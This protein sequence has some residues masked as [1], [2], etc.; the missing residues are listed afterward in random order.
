MTPVSGATFITYPTVTVVVAGGVVTTV[1]LVTAGI[2]ASSTAATV[3]TVAAALIG[4]T[5]SGFSIAVST[6]VTGASN[7][8]IGYQT[9]VANTAGSS[10][11][12][13]GYRAGNT[14]VS[15]GNNLI[16]G[17]GAA[18]STTTVS[19]EITL[20]NGSIT[21]FRIPGLSITAAASALTIGSQFAVTNTASAVNY[22]QATGAATGVSPTIS[23]QGSDTNID[24][25]LTPKGTG[26]VRFGTLTANADAAITGYITIKDSSGTLRKLAV[27]A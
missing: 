27:I 6:F 7:T 20:G 24:L 17:N 26:N 8:A 15:G 22:V 14:L 18:V 23:A 19:N 4:G 10:N 1:T 25:A 2:I 12:A 9:L 11:T 5:G 21:A 16:L 13:L 3:L